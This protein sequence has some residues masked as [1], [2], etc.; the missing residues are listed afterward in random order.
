M[1]TYQTFTEYER[2]EDFKRLEFIV[3]QIADRGPGPLRILDI[4]C[5]NGNIALALG[6]L[7]H[8]VVGVDIDADSIQIATARNPFKHVSFRQTDVAS[9]SLT[10]T[11]DALVCSEVLEHLPDPDSL[12]ASAH[13]LL[14]PGGRLIVTVPNGYGPRE[15]LMTRPMQWMHQRGLASV[16]HTIKRGFGYSNTTL[17]SANPDLTH[18]QFFTRKGLQ[19]M[20]KTNGFRLQAFGKGD[21]VNGIFPYSILTRRISRLQQLDCRLADLLPPTFASGFYTAW[22]K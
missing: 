2:V 16:L 8:E 22:V 14:R 13:R 9:M 18:L 17:Q 11:F 19:Q 12:V 3:S 21:C 1:T 20:L 15:L 10:D 5:G 6:S 4:G 7:G